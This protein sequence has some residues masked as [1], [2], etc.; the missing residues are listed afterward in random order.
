MFLPVIKEDKCT[1]CRECAR[2]CPKMVLDVEDE[3]IKVS[4][5]YYCT[6]CE[7]CSVVCPHRA[8]EVKEI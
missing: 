3:E 4:D 6:G 2:I 1:G 7:S 8:I 5:A